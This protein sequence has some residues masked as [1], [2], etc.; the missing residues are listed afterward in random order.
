MKKLILSF[1]FAVATLFIFNGNMLGQSA[2]CQIDLTSSWATTPNWTVFNPVPA[3][4]CTGQTVTFSLTLNGSYAWDIVGNYPNTNGFIRG[5]NGNSINEE[6]G[7]L[8]IPGNYSFVITIYGSGCNRDTTLNVA[9]L[10]PPV[11]NVTVNDADVCAGTSITATATGG[12]LGS[13]TY[14]WTVNSLPA[15]GFDPALNTYSYTPIN[16]DIINCSISNGTCSDN[17]DTPIVMTV[18]T[19]PVPIASF[20]DLNLQNHFCNSQTAIIEE[21]SGNTNIVSYQYFIAGVSTTTGVDS[22]SWIANLAQDLQTAYIVVTDN[23][24]CTGT[25]NVLTINVDRLPDL[26]VAPVP[27]STCNGEYMTIEVSGFTGEGAGPW[28]VEFWNPAHTVQYP[29]ISSTPALPTSTTVTIEVDIPYGSN[30]TNVK[31]TET[32]TGCTN[33]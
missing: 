31:L 30:G 32:T 7:M 11:A 26:T 10:S 25:S 17:D 13:S 14:N 3:T 16:G 21:T 29:I 12:I 8:N 5:G 20:D 9:V 24:G 19:N 22:H 2:N 6:T 33:F 4:V 27:S 1:F 28:N 15:V 18:R 23:N